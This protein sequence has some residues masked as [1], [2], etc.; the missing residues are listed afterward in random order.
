[1]SLDPYLFMSPLPD[2][3]LCLICEKQRLEITAWWTGF[4]RKQSKQTQT[5][6]KSNLV[7]ALYLV[8]TQEFLHRDNVLIQVQLCLQ[9]GQSFLSLFCHVGQFFLKLS[10]SSCSESKGNYN[11]DCNDGNGIKL[12]YRAR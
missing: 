2:G 1:M 11:T 9:L 4:V 5:E 3:G 7:D 10:H 8:A 12:F 6:R